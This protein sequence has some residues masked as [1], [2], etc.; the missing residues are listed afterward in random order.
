MQ[1]KSFHCLSHHGIWAIILFKL[2]EERKK[3]LPVNRLVNN[4]GHS[5]LRSAVT[6]AVLVQWS[7]WC[8]KLLLPF[9]CRSFDKETCGTGQRT[10]FYQVCTICR[11]TFTQEK[12]RNSW[13]V[14]ADWWW[15]WL[16]FD[17]TER[18]EVREEH[19]KHKNRPRLLLWYLLDIT[20][21]LKLIWIEPCY[22]CSGSNIASNFARL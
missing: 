19:C 14:R 16:V 21:R 12:R 9:P 13:K 6:N 11:H 5:P 1:F 10:R 3:L 8:I 7:Y 2:V 15:A 18:K 22:F 17:N 4:T 20:F